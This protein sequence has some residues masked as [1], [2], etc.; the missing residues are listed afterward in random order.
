MKLFSCSVETFAQSLRQRART[1]AGNLKSLHLTHAI[2]VNRRAVFEVK[3]DRAEDLREGE[4]L[5]FAK[6]RL[7]RKSFIETFDDRIE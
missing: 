1:T 6:D 5:E 2:G 3:G 7:G 4:S